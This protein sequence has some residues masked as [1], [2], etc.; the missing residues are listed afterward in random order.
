MVKFNASTWW[1]GFSSFVWG[2]YAALLLETLVG[3]H[4]WNVADAVFLMM[5]TLTYMFVM[6]I[7]FEKEEEPEE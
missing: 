6:A 7:C 2:L 1:I 4:I 3:N 5:Y